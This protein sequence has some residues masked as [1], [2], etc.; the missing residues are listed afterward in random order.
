M[1][2]V[3]L[4]KKKCLHAFTLHLEDSSRQE[5]EPLDNKTDAVLSCPMCFT[6]LCYSCQR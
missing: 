1:R 3:F 2:R 6:N 4:I 5:D